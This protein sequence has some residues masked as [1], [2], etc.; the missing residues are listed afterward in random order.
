MKCPND[1]SSTGESLMSGS[2]Y[3]GQKF[4]V[5]V[6][7]L[8]Y[9]GHELAGY[10]GTYLQQH[11]IT[12]AAFAKPGSDTSQPVGGFDDAK[13]LLINSVDGDGNL[14]RLLS[15]SLPNAFTNTNPRSLKW[16]APTPIYLR[17]TAA[18]QT[19]NALGQPTAISVT[20]KDQGFESGVTVLSG[21]LLL[22]NAFGSELLKLPVGVTAQYWTGS[23]WEN[24]TVDNSSL[25]KVAATFSQCQNRLSTV[26]S[27]AANCKPALALIPASSFSLTNGAGKLWLQPPGTGNN[28][29]GYMDITANGSDPALPG[30]LGRVTFGIYKS[31]LIYI[32]E[33]Y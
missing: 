25:I 26:A 32:R 1:L 18:E 8:S 30:T 6:K 5:S 14:A 22:A 13:A 33:V 15:Y 27:G 12:L 10:S 4:N 7:A 24:N 28:G 9:L 21:R 29:S 2:V 17:A 3:S 20:S 16:T 23:G 31:P 11:P 19:V